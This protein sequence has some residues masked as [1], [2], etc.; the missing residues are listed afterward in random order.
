MEVATHLGTLLS[1]IVVFRNEIISLIT[2]IKI[3]KSI[4]R[5]FVIIGTIPAV[6][7]GLFVKIFIF[8]LIEN[9]LVVAI[10][11]FITY[12][13]KT[14]KIKIRS[15]PISFKIAILIGLSQAVAV[16][17]G[18]SR[19]GITIVTALYLGLCKEEAAKFSFLAIP[20]ILEREF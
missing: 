5:Y 17:P 1:I 16:F 18:I 4:L 3:K 7:F 19:S 6:A 15:L 20:V 9:I 10:S 12:S 2:G 11:L 13:F 14:K 8:D